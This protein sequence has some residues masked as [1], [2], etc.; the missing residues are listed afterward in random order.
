MFKSIVVAFD[1][2]QPASRALQIGSGLAGLE[3]AALGI[4]YVVDES[5]LFIP[6]DLRR[7]AEIEHVIDPA[8]KMLINYENVPE[9][10]MSNL[11]RASADSLRA[12]QQYAEFLLRQAAEN[13]RKAGAKDVETTVEQ[14]DPAEEVIAYAKDRAAD[15]IVCGNR[16]MG[17]WKSLLLGSTSSRITQL[18]ECSCLTVK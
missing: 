6:E 11:A 7:T 1:G 15:L 17:R 8:P 9:A 3:Q 18:A 12:I 2:S 14:G 4:V 5:R 16:G 13:A 10:M